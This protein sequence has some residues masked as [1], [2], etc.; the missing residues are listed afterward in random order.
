MTRGAASELAGSIGSAA[1]SS[2]ASQAAGVLGP[3]LPT[4]AGHA[5]SPFGTDDTPGVALVAPSPEHAAPAP[6]CGHCAAPAG[7]LIRATSM[8]TAGR[9]HCDLAAR[10]GLWTTAHEPEAVVAPVTMAGVD[11]GGAAGAASAS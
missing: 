11:R 2:V 4:V 1:G 6:E 10:A 7:T 3:G 5:L 8:A 9:A